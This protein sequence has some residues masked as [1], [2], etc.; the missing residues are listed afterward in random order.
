MARKYFTIIISVLFG[1][2]SMPGQSAPR[3]IDALVER[4]QSAF[5]VPGIAV[6]IVKDGKI[7][8]AKGYGVR[9]VGTGEKV[10]G[11]TN[12]SIASNTKAFTATA[13]ALL[14]EEGKLQWNDRV[15]DHLPWFQMSDPYVTREMRIIDLLVHRSGLG[16]GAGDLLLWPSTIYET[17][18]IVRRLRYVPLATSFRSAYA[19]DNV[20]Y[21]VA[22]EVVEA[23]SGMPWHEFIEKR[24]MNVVGMSGST[25]TYAD[26]V[27]K[28]NAATPH[29][30]IAHRVQIVHP[31]DGTKT[32]PA[33]SINSNAEDMA[34]W[35]ICQLDSGK[36]VGGTRLFSQKT[37]RTSWTLVTP[38]P[39]RTEPQE[40]APLRRN[41]NGYGLGFF[42]RDYRGR[43]LVMH[44]GGLNGF[45]SLV[46][47]IP[48]LRVGVAVLTN[49]E[50]TRAFY[51]IG[52]HVLDYYLNAHYD[53]LSAY[54]SVKAR[55]DS[56]AEVADRKTIVTRDSL[57]HPSLNLARYAGTYSDNWYGS[58]R[59]DYN[60]GNLSIHMVPSP[61][62][63]GTLEHY[64]FDTFI[65]RWDDP[66]LRADAFV[67]FCLDPKGNIEQVKMKAVSPATDF[68]Y[69]FQ[70]LVLTPAGK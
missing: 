40:L 18:E 33:G 67:T 52:W 50:E 32:D 47:M 16:L 49:Q 46:A 58:V 63:K 14:V 28:G 41:F 31:S 12:F 6:A 36:T 7:V 11:K 15:I 69:D 64:Q 2:A 20:L 68:S 22:G 65:A 59:I 26:A 13:L 27:K 66:E 56:I 38:I 51:S 19:Y 57:S 23:V 34:R 44:T 70:D 35:M 55:E 30:L 39:M 43:K 10:D 8:L 3:D 60:G 25:T 21:L 53:W 61:G 48:E 17:K 5:A 24:I 37:T 9:T 4:V 42:L 62:M 45:V 1:C 29:A 54:Q